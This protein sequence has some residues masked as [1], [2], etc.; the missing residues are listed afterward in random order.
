MIINEIILEHLLANLLFSKSIICTGNIKIYLSSTS[1]YRPK[2]KVAIHG[3]R[4][5][6]TCPT[7][8]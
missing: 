3:F 6:H 8:I 1:K 5:A 4:T 7:A 2:P